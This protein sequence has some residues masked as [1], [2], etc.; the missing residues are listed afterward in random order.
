EARELLSER[1]QLSRDVARMAVASA[2]RERQQVVGPQVHACASDR[3]PAGRLAESIREWNRSGV[4][5][6]PAQR[7][8]ATVGDLRPGVRF[9][10]RHQAGDTALQA[11][12]RADAPEAPVAAE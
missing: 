11:V 3:M 1:S 6:Q 12:G 9:A 10:R 7:D 4:T 8:R 2:G 5:V